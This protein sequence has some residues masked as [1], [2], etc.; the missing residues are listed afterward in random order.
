MRLVQLTKPTGAEGFERWCIHFSIV[1]LYIYLYGKRFD[2]VSQV[3]DEI[4]CKLRQFLL[5]ISTMSRPAKHVENN[6]KNWSNGFTFFLSAHPLDIYSK[7]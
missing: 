3:F 4:F 6:N 7:K 2:S 5:N 1:V